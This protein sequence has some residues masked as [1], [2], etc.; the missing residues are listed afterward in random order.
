MVMKVRN[1]TLRGGGGGGKISVFNQ[2]GGVESAVSLGVTQLIWATQDGLG[3]SAVVDPDDPTRVIIGNPPEFLD[4][5]AWSSAQN[6][7]VRVSES[8]LAEADTFLTNGQENTTVMGSLN[9]LNYSSTQGRGFGADARITVKTYHNGVLVDDVTFSAESNGTQTDGNV[10]VQIS[11][12]APDGDGTADAARFSVSVSGDG[13]IG[14]TNSGVC[15]VEISFLEHKWA[16]LRNINQDVFRDKNPDSPSI[17]GA[18]SIVEDPTPANIVTKF[19]SGLQY[20]TL[21]SPFV[22]SVP[23]IDNHNNDSSRPN[24]SLVVDSSD[25]GITPYTSSPWTDAPSWFEVT[26]L[27]TVQGIDYEETKNINETDFRHVGE[28]SVG[29]II[30]DSWNPAGSVA[31]NTLD[32]CIDTFSNTSTE[33]LETF[34][35][36]DRRLKHDYTT[37]WDSTVHLL[38]GDAA[39]FG[40]KLVHPADMFTINQTTTEGALGSITDFTS[41]LPFIATQPNYTGFNRYCTYFREFPTPNINSFSTFTVTVGVNG[42]LKTLLENEDLRI[43]IWKLASTD[44]G[45]PNIITPPNYNI[46]NQDFSKRNSIWVHGAN[47]Y[48]FAEFRDGLL[49]TNTNATCR[50]SITGTTANCTFGSFNVE[51]GILMRVEFERG[52][53]VEEISVSFA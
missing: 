16:V 21:T 4:P 51:N 34:N 42:D 47:V 3:F 31:S 1:T 23:D 2:S 52:V 40:G 33:S 35:S 46:N 53:C 9:N 28:A 26:N 22:I 6:T 11:G 20:Y 10:S 15:R 13:L 29:N 7:P 38:D 12:Y 27:D 18:P 45:S 17:T 43:Y 50:S 8:D 39:V 25:F 24:D 49:Q 19:L 48:N 36:E 41:N 30:R 44:A 37:A 14:S 32:V 5:I